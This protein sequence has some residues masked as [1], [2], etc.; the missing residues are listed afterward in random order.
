MLQTSKALFSQTAGYSKSFDTAADAENHQNLFDTD[1]ADDVE[2]NAVDKNP[3]IKKRILLKSDPK[4]VATGVNIETNEIESDFTPFESFN[5]DT[6]KV[7]ENAFLNRIDT[8]DEIKNKVQ[9]MNETESEVNGEIASNVLARKKDKIMLD[10]IKY[11]KQQSA[12]AAAMK[13]NKDINVQPQAADS[14]VQQTQQANN[15]GRIVVY[16]DSNCLDSTH[17]EKPCFWLLDA[18]LEYTMTSHI[19]TLLKDLNRSATIKFDNDLNNMPKRLPNNNLHLYSKVLMPPTAE[20]DGSAENNAANNDVYSSPTGLVKR[21]LLQCARIQWETPIFL[22]I[23]APIDLQNQNGRSKDDSDA[24]SMNIVG[25][26]SLRR[27]LE[28]QKGEVC[29]DECYSLVF[30]VLFIVLMCMSKKV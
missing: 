24:D 22:N 30:F 17:I 10:K 18:L 8:M 7:D 2:A 20:K 28:S 29:S 6:D 21:P 3:I 12:T 25:E 27:K 1:K 4:T 14:V 19:S 23:T 26:L 15:E 16:G 11:S 5:G 9:D 13:L